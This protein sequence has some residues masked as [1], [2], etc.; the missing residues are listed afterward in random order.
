MKST[1]NIEFSGDSIIDGFTK[2]LLE[3]YLSNAVWERYKHHGDYYAP[4]DFK[5]EF[6]L[7]DLKELSNVE[8][9]ERVI[10]KYGDIIELVYK[11]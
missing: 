3:E 6:S 8:G 4:R 5:Q 2:Q 9:I 7:E 1:F 10:I 11:Y